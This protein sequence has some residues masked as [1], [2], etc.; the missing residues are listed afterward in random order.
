MEY[1]DIYPQDKLPN[2]S[3]RDYQKLLNEA[4]E[5]NAY[6]SPEVIAYAKTKYSLYENQEQEIKDLCIKN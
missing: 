4:L 5:N 6:N 2:L 1:S 3:R